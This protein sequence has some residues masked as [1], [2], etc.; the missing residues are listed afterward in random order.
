MYSWTSKRFPEQYKDYL[1]HRRTNQNEKEILELF[2]I[3][4]LVMKSSALKHQPTKL[5]INVSMYPNFLIGNFLI[6]NMWSQVNSKD[7]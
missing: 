3:D 2:N 1:L 7:R 4:S 6:V 5:K